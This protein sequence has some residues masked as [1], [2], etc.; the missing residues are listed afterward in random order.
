MI[1]RLIRAKAG[2]FRDRE[3]VRAWARGLEAKIA[4]A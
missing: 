1:I 4:R 2:D 3:A